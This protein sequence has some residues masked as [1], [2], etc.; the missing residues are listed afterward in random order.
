VIKQDNKYTLDKVEINKDVYVVEIIGGW[1][2]RQRLNQ[3]GIHPG[4]KIIVKRSGIMKGPLH[5]KVHGMEVALGRGMAKK[6]VIQE[7][8]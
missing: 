5:I 8:A 3:M 7:K 2:I 4:D 6:V 1:G